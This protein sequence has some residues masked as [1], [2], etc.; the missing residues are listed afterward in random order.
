MNAPGVVTYGVA[1]F[2]YNPPY[3]CTYA[4]SHVE[5]CDYETVCGSTNTNIVSVSIDTSSEFYIQNW[6]EQLDAYCLPKPFI[7]YMGAMAFMGAALACFFL[8]M[9]CDMYGRKYVFI[10]SSAS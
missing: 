4:D 7:G 3:L 1:Y 10:I 5:S 6:I 8:P 2:E 9:F